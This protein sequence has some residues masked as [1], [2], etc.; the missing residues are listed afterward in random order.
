M[1][2]V[3]NWRRS[4]AYPETPIV[5][6]Q[7]PQPNSPVQN[8]ASQPDQNLQPQPDNRW[9]PNSPV[10]NAPPQTYRPSQTLQPQRDTQEQNLQP[11]VQTVT[12]GGFLNA[13]EER[14]ELKS[15]SIYPPS[16]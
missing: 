9:Q 3:D 5:P 12:L 8:I 16:K 4:F 11:P 1:A 10:Q 13:D 7:Q 14:T 2:E 15:A 6:T